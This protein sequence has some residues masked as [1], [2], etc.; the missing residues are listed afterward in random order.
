M[1]LPDLSLILVVV[2]FWA[3]YVVLRRFLLTPLGAVLAAREAALTDPSRPHPTWS[4][5]QTLAHLVQTAEAMLL[6]PAPPEGEGAAAGD[7]GVV[8]PLGAMRP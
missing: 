2:I 5:D 8:G 6:A 7:P 1:Q 3:A 4:S